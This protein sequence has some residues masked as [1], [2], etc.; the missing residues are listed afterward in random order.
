MKRKGKIRARTEPADG[1][2]RRSTEAASGQPT[3]PESPEDFALTDDTP[4]TVPGISNFGQLYEV[5]GRYSDREFPR[6]VFEGEAF[7]RLMESGADQEWLRT[8]CEEVAILRYMQQFPVRGRGI[9]RNFH[10]SLAKAVKAGAAL[11]SLP[12]GSAYGQMRHEL[13]LCLGH[14]QRCE[15]TIGDFIQRRGRQDSA[16]DRGA[17]PDEAADHFRWQVEHYPWVKRPAD[18]LLVELLK[19]ITGRKID[20]DSFRRARRRDRKA[21][22]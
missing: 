12:S 21:N 17:P 22:R 18:S 9:L 8:L 16:A 7:R 6:R 19:D 4:L 14:M 3:R 10:R 15:K 13:L 2:S 20:L 5:Y 1:A 11:N